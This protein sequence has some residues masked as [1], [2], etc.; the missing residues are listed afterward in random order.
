[1]QTSRQFDVKV[2]TAADVLILNFKVGEESEREKET[3]PSKSDE[4]F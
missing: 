1:V 3:R 4:H 2:I